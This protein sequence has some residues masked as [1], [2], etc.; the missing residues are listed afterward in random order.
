MVCLWFRRLGYSKLKC[1]NWAHQMILSNSVQAFTHYSCELP[2]NKSIFVL[3]CSNLLPHD[4]CWVCSTAPHLLCWTCK[5]SFLALF[6][7]LLT[8][9]LWLWSIPSRPKNQ[10]LTTS[11]Q[12]VLPTQCWV[13][14]KVTETGI[15][16]CEDF[17]WERWFKLYSWILIWLSS[18]LY[19]VSDWYSI[20]DYWE[21]VVSIAFQ[22]SENMGHTSVDLSGSIKFGIGIFL[23]LMINSY[24]MK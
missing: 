18:M 22:Y 6:P 8:L 12:L 7:L 14:V 17:K 23:H 13:T 9:W 24:V 2:G 11:S 21:A 5:S 10:F 3:E 20:S 16:V 4:V 19:T 15:A 1:M